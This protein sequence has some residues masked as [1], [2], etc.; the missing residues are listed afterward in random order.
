MEYL[1]RLDPRWEGSVL[2]I[3]F[4]KLVGQGSLFRHHFRIL[5]SR[6]CT[7][8]SVLSCDAKVTSSRSVFP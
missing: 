4:W 5:C 2:E 7:D 8:S 1:Y 6:I 3:L